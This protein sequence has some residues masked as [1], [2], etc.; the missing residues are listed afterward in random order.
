MHRQEDAQQGQKQ[1]LVGVLLKKQ[2][3]E[4]MTCIHTATLN[5]RHCS[6]N[7][8]TLAAFLPD[9]ADTFDLVVRTVELIA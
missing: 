2:L 7:P 5:C 4:R 8:E 9:Q 6:M 1:K 3:N